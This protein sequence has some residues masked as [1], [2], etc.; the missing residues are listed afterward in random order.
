V[1]EPNCSQ[2][3]RRL[4]RNRVCLRPQSPIPAGFL[5]RGEPHLISIAP[6]QRQ[7]WPYKSLDD[8]VPHLHSARRL[9]RSA[10]PLVKPQQP[11][12]A[13]RLFAVSSPAATV[14]RSISSTLPTQAAQ[15]HGHEHEDHYDPPGGW[16]WGIPP[17]QKYQ[18]E[19]WESPLYYGVIGSL[20]A[21]GVAYAFKPDTRYLVD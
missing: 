10:M 4:R 2:R 3:T 14:H 21:A 19:G 16:L 6:L 1:L 18:R 8:S 7:H 17:G 20:I 15:S 13:T 9:I 11:L 5:G 12:K